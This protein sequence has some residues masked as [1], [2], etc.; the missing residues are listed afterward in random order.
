MRLKQGLGSIVLGVLFVAGSPIVVCAGDAPEPAPAAG[1]A[2]AAASDPAAAPDVT[3]PP[4]PAEEGIPAGDAAAGE[5]AD[6][7]VEGEEPKK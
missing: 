5:D 7:A 1:P 6:T 3:A 2:P 4:S